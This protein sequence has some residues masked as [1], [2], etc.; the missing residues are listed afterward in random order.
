[1]TRV[2]EKDYLYDGGATVCG[3]PG[4]SS[5]NGVSGLTQHDETNYGPTANVPGGNMTQTVAWLSG[6]SSPTTTYTYDETGQVISVNDPCGNA[7]CSDMTGTNHIT[8]YSYTDSYASGF[9]TPPGNTNSYVTTITYPTVGAITTHEYFQYA[10][11]DGQLTASQDDNQRSASKSNTYTYADSLRRLTQT[12]YADGGRV[13]ISYNDTAPSP[14]ITKTTLIDSTAGINLGT[15]TVLDGLGHVVQTQ[16]TTDPEGVNKTDTT[17]DGLG[18]VWKQSN[19]YR[20]TSDPTYG[21]TTYTYD[22]LGRVKSVAKPDQSTISTTYSGNCTTV[23]DE[24]GKSRQSCTDAF[25]RLTKV[26][27]DPAVLNYETD[28]Q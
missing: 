1:V 24:T 19:P 16:I 2:A 5:V 8:T 26:L 11:S 23:T 12:D 28:Y 21:I 13:T 14:T 25:G 3:A 4:A 9:G 7:T 18:R 17:Y 6:G 10:Y 27:E 22:A 15:K 20:G